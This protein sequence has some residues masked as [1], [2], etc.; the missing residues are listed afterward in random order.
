MFFTQLIISKLLPK[1]CEN[2][3]MTFSVI[4]FIYQ[5]IQLFNE[6]MSGKTV[7][8]IKVGFMHNESLP[9]ISICPE[10]LALNRLAKI[11]QRLAHLYQTYRH[12][13]TSNQS[14][15]VT[16]KTELK[17]ILGRF[18]TLI[19]EHLKNSTNNFTMN[20]LVNN[21][22]VPFRL[23]SDENLMRVQFL[24]LKSVWP[25]NMSKVITK[26]KDSEIW[27]VVSEPMETISL[28]HYRT[29]KRDRL[30][31]CFTFFSQTDPTWRGVK[32]EFDLMYIEI[33]VDMSIFPYSI[34]NGFP[35]SLHS[36]DNLPIYRETKFITLDSNYFIS[37][38]KWKIQRLGSGYDT[39]C[40]DYDP[41][42]KTRSDCIAECYQSALSI[43]CPTKGFVVSEHFVRKEYFEENPNLKANNCSVDEMSANEAMA[44]CSHLCH[45]ECLYSYY[46]LSLDR[47]SRSEDNKVKISVRH[48][49]TPDLTIRHVPEMS[50]VT[51]VCNF[52]GLLGM[53]LGVSFLAIMDQVFTMVIRLTIKHAVKITNYN[54]QINLINVDHNIAR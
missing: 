49:E 15:P 18:E 39:D 32:V 22:M 5:T 34:R 53:W 3:L 51:L 41:R 35:V 29:S 25:T 47:V 46:T 21:Y 4:C 52:G 45:K 19:I 26:S 31:K 48:S 40:H 50:F 13:I 9:A 43:D 8:A 16:T 28:V 23:T 42:L 36:P 10:G 14:I 38:S 2:I 33:T 20:E 6:Y 44:K 27:S 30:F 12:I 54:N 37:F 1:I 24:A 17:D 11:D 7:T